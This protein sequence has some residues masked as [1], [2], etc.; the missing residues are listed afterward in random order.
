[1]PSAVAL[2]PRSF[3]ELFDAASLLLREHFRPLA[4][5]AATVAI[6]ALLINV[7]NVVINGPAPAF[8][9]T[10]P[11]DMRQLMTT[12]P[13][14]VLVLCWSF[15]GV[16]A[17]LRAASDAYL[18]LPVDPAGSL[19][20]AVGRAGGLIGS[21]LL[22][23]AAGML[24]LAAAMVVMVLV[25]TLLVVGIRMVG[26]PPAGTAV[27]G[28]VLGATGAAGAL[29]AMAAVLARYANVSAVIMLEGA[30]AT[31]ALRRSSAL[32]AGHLRR[33]VG[34]FAILMVFSIVFSLLAVGLGAATG[35]G[36]VA[37][38]VSTLLWV[39][40]YPVVACLL[41]A[42]YYDLR[43]RKEG[44]DIAYAALELGEVPRAVPAA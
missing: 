25:G 14:S 38:V 4:T 35:N 29:A 5:L 30:G 26:L 9:A 13:A 40:I 32:G 41:T 37:Q 34:L 33:I 36:Y 8:G 19:R 7:A 17:L 18:G 15:V 31:A 6:P 39:P 22:A 12:I 1:M 28:G 27:L 43:I 42:L 23:Y 11:A 3:S 24:A 2:R 21:H 16:G 20:E 44:F 10:A